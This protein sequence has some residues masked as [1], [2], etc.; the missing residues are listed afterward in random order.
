MPIKRLQTVAKVENSAQ[1]CAKLKKKTCVFVKF[2]A[3]HGG[4]QSYTSQAP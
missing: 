1:Y 4:G 2:F 3:S